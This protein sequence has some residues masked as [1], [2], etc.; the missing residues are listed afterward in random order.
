MLVCFVSITAEHCSQTALVSSRKASSLRQQ[1]EQ[2]KEVESQDAPPSTSLQEA[3]PPPPMKA[4]S[5]LLWPPD[6]LEEGLNALDDP[7]NRDEP[8]PLF[9]NELMA[10]GT[11]T[12]NPS[13]HLALLALCCDKTDDTAC[14]S[15]RW[16]VRYSCSLKLTAISLRLPAATSIPMRRLLSTH[17]HLK[18]LLIKLSKVPNAA[19]RFPLE[20]RVRSILGLSESDGI[21]QHLSYRPGDGTVAEGDRDQYGFPRKQNGLGLGMDEHERA[22]L[23]EFNELVKTVLS[24]ERSKR[25]Q[26]RQ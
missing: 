15:V 3:Q 8:K 10:I 25:S 19:P 9:H 17:P 2:P 11:H 4:L 12:P 23:R 5:S 6:P 13:A 21:P 20:H 16:H 24:E 22:A 18:D 7:L 1:E 14:G 26:V